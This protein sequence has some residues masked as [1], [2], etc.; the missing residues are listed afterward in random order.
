MNVFCAITVCA[1]AVGAA[2][3]QLDSFRKTFTCLLMCAV[4]RG[5]ARDARVAY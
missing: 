5:M 1:A 2:N 4:W 3:V